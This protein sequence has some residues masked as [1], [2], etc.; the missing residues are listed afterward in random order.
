MARYQEPL[1]AGAGG[2]VAV[3]T[4]FL[5]IVQPSRCHAATLSDAMIA[6]TLAQRLARFGLATR[7][8]SPNEGLLAAD[9]STARSFCASL[10][11]A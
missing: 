2:E 8:S 7:H 4:P 10:K 5:A 11:S 1:A 9:N 3:E 6:D